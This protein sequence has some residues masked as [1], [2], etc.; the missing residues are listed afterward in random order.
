MG[1]LAGK[2]ALITGA[3][4]GIGA[5]QVEAFVAEGASVVFTDLAQEVAEGSALRELVAGERTLYSPQD[6]TSEAEWERVVALVEERF[7]GLDILV[8]TAGDWLFGTVEDCALEEWDRMVAVNQ[9]GTFLGMKHA[10]A[11]MRRRGGGSIINISS[12]WGSAGVAGAVG[13][14]ASK[15]A[16]I[17]LT[18]NAAVTLAPADIRVNAILPGMIRTEHLLAN[19]ADRNEATLANTPLGRMGSGADIAWGTVYLASDEA[20][21]VTGATLAID[22]GYLAH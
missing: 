1:R 6:V 14:Q 9:T 15:G 4:G 7:G 11:A 18:K 22:G 2:V 17:T 13:Y 5:A 20:A 3:T 21:F 16:V 8:N 10:A 19:P 12:I